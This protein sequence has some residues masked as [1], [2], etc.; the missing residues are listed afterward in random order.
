[1]TDFST[2]LY[3]SITFIDQLNNQSKFKED[4]MEEGDNMEG[5]VEQMDEGENV[6]GDDDLTFCSCFLE[7]EIKMN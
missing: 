7:A 1:M 3:E 2:C 4:N 5:D 6:E